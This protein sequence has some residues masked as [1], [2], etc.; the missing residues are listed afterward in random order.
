MIIAQLKNSKQK[1]SEHLD[2]ASLQKCILKF[3]GRHQAPNV[4]KNMLNESCLEK[5]YRQSNLVGGFNDPMWK[6][7]TASQKVRLSL[8]NQ[9]GVKTPSHVKDIRDIISQIGWTFKKYFYLTT[10]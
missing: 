10:T 4:F 1:N 3:D 5:T 9:S 2:L 8:K 7:E 6:F